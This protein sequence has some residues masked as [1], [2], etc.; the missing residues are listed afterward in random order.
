[1]DEQEIIAVLRAHVAR[2]QSNGSNGDNAVS[3]GEPSRVDVSKLDYLSSEV[4]RLSNGVGHL[5]PRNP[6]ALNRVAQAFKRII[7]RSLSWYTRSL[8]DYHHLVNQSLD[9]HARSIA[10]LQQQI[11]QKDGGLPE[12]LQETLRTERRAT[13]EQQA[14]YADLFRGLEPVLDLGCGRGEFLE[15]LEAKGISAYGID[16]DRLACEEAQRKSLTVIQGDLFQNLEQVPDRSLGGIFCSR[17]LEYL[18]SHVQA[19]VIASAGAKLKPGGLLV[20]ETL[21]PGSDTPFGR[22]SHIDPTHLRA[23]YPEVLK[24]LVESTGFECK[25]CVLAP[26]QVR[27]GEAREGLER[28]DLRNDG[29]GVVFPASL[30]RATSYSVIA[31]RR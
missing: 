3:H 20:I 15:L 27:V 14:P 26:Q 30:S 29:Q 8:Q 2:S 10:L 7:R 1:M 31:T 21:N 22:N 9:Y 11:A 24:S 4:W 18:P 25:I 19:D 6:G 17:V 28:S 23:I 12:L 13:Q 16:S 5:N